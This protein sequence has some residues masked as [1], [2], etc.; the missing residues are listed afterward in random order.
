M[1]NGTFDRLT[2]LKSCRSFALSGQVQ[3]RPGMRSVWILDGA[4]IHCHPG[5]T[6]YLRSLGIIPV[7]L[8][9]YCPFFNPI[10]YFFGFVKKQMR[11]TYQEATTKHKDIVKVISTIL[12]CFRE[13]NMRNVFKHCGFSPS[14]CFNPGTAFSNDWINHLGFN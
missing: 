5:F 11:R 10:E 1:T 3:Q 2:F 12:D 6:Y 14:G 7:F 8:P 13:Y 4:R 9:A